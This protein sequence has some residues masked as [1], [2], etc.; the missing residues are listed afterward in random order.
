DSQQTSAHRLTALAAIPNGAG[1][2]DKPLFVFLS[3]ELRP[4]NTSGL[5]GTAADILAHAKLTSEQLLE[6]TGAFETVRPLEVDRLLEFYAQST[7]E[8]VGQ[9]LIPVLTNSPIRPSLRTDAIKQR[10]AKSP[11]SV[12]K[13]AEEL[14]A[15]IN[16]E[17]ERQR[18][19]LE[20]LLAGTKNGDVRRGQ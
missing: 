1:A 10:I 9:P 17:H 7:A 15:L 2:I 14:Y 19:H 5:R 12:Q 20:K 18:A 8:K 3:A 4:E 16:V 13:Q 6:L 11:A